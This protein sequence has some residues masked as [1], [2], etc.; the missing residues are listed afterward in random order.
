MCD[1]CAKYSA[2]SMIWISVSDR[3][4]KKHCRLDERKQTIMY[5]SHIGLNI[6]CICTAHVFSSTNNFSTAESKILISKLKI[7]TLKLIYGSVWYSYNWK[8]NYI[9]D[10][11]LLRDHKSSRRHRLPGKHLVFGCYVFCHSN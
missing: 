2:W 8:L 11:R 1:V 7:Y 3:P 4:Y 10:S 5:L 9:P 6:C